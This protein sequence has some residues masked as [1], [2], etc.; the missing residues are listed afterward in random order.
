MTDYKKRLENGK[1]KSL[2]QQ[3]REWLESTFSQDYLKRKLK[4]KVDE[5]S[6]IESEVKY[7][8]ERYSIDAVKRYLDIR[9]KKMNLTP[10][11]SSEVSCEHCKKLVNKDLFST[12]KTR[13]CIKCER[14]F[15]LK[16]KKDIERI[17][18]SRCGKPARNQMPLL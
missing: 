5:I 16:N 18:E 6:K 9:I 3:K 7:R 13:I 15:E 8:Q 1:I 2:R 10:G 14:K 11:D 17:R 12:I 4:L